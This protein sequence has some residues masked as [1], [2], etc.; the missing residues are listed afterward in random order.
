M[1]EVVDLFKSKESPSKQETKLT[2]EIVR[3]YK[4]VILLV[5]QY[6]DSLTIEDWKNCYLMMLSFNDLMMKYIYEELNQ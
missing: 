2:P 6:Q 1:G 3:E 4:E 5:S